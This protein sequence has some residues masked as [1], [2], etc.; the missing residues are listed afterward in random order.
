MKTR[1]RRRSR[2]TL[3][4]RS[5]ATPSTP[6]TAGDSPAARAKLFANGRSQAVRLPKEF[7][8]PGR[9]VLIRRDGTRIVLQPLDE[10]GLPAGFWQEIDRLT[11]GIDFPDPEPLAGGLLDLSPE[12]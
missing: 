8:L 5:R 6:L 2:R 10:S 7:R 1:S 3:P 9:E 11:A 12:Q 4:A